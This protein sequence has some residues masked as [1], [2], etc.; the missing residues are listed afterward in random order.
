MVGPSGCAPSLA[1]APHLVAAWPVDGARLSLAPQ[2][3]ELTFNRALRPDATRASVASDDGGVALRARAMVEPADPRRLQI[4]VFDPM[5]GRFEVRWH[6]VAAE[7]GAVAEGNQWL[8]F[9]PQSPAPAR[10]DVAPGLA[11]AG[12]RLELVGKGFGRDS[13]VVLTIGDDAQPLT[14]T[15]TDASGKFNL[16]AHVPATVPLGMQPVEASDGDGHQAIGSVEVRWG[17]WP[18]VRAFDVGQP[19][20]DAGDV[21]FSVTVRNLSDYVLEHVRVVLADPEGGALVSFD[22]GGQRQDGALVWEFPVMDRG[23]VG[24]IRATYRAGRASQRLVSRAQLEFRHR[25]E[26]GC[27]G[28]YCLPAFISSTNA[29]STAVAPSD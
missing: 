16:E 10:I 17:G 9:Q 23:G 26:R 13:P 5:A 12:D 29:D 19:G 28:G 6:V 1:A 4:R 27:S 24:P 2:T 25:A 3:L 22:P 7:S 21:T 15:S 20:P 14:T 11:E 18:P 8:T